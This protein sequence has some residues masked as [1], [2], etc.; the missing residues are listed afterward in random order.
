LDTD[1]KRNIRESLVYALTQVKNRAQIRLVIQ[2][3]YHSLNRKGILLNYE[4][5]EEISLADQLVDDMAANWQF[6]SEPRK[7]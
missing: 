3:F 6:V 1:L 7:G 5:P 2:E 4:V